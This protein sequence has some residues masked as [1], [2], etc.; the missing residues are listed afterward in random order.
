MKGCLIKPD[1]PVK[2]ESQTLRPSAAGDECMS[3][4]SVEYCATFEAGNTA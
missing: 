2:M 3:T 1:G 4:G